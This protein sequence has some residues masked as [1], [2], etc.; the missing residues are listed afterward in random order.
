M[1]GCTLAGRW[2]EHSRESDAAQPAAE[3]TSHSANGDPEHTVL[4]CA[5]LNGRSNSQQ[6]ECD[7][8]AELSDDAGD[9]KAKQ[10]DCCSHAVSRRGNVTQPDCGSQYKKTEE[11]V[12]VP[13][14]N[15]W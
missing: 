13:M 2:R 11:N 4:K 3:D 5:C 9:R 1:L 6:R 15:G 7:D 8:Q 10:R 12:R 14:T